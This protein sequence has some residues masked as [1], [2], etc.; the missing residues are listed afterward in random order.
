M[1]SS[2]HHC[3]KERPHPLADEDE[4]PLPGG[5]SFPQLVPGGRNPATI[6]SS[7]GPLLQ[8]WGRAYPIWGPRSLTTEESR[9]QGQEKQSPAV[10]RC[11]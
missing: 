1:H 10:G 7:M 3:V 11:E 5:D 2:L 6:H 9:M 4:F 8:P